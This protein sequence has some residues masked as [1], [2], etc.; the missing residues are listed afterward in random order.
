MFSRSLAAYCS[1]AV[2]C[3]AASF[4]QTKG[5]SVLSCYVCSIIRRVF[6]GGHQC[7]KA[8]NGRLSWKLVL[9]EVL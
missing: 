9:L 5:V 6:P 3:D 7:N 1:S 8:Q 2:T 4:D